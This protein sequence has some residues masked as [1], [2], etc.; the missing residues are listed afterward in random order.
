MCTS[1]FSPLNPTRICKQVRLTC[2]TNFEG[3]CRGP[4]LGSILYASSP[5]LSRKVVSLRFSGEV[6]GLCIWQ[7]RITLLLHSWSA[8]AI[9]SL[10]HLQRKSKGKKNPSYIKLQ[11]QQIKAWMLK[12]TQMWLLLCI[13][14]T[15]PSH[16]TK[17]ICFRWCR[18]LL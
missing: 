5:E 1:N 10:E 16:N 4:S 14:I 18:T 3:Y 11:R 13:D 2:R 17:P 12:T 7:I 15:F 9:F 6:H 8:D